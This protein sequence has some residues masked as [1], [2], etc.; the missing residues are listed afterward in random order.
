[1]YH[2]LTMPTK[3]TCPMYLDTHNTYLGMQDAYIGEN[4]CCYDRPMCVCVYYLDD[5]LNYKIVSFLLIAIIPLS[6]LL[7]FKFPINF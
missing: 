3:N 6:Y 5:V 4:A 2:S 1:M 7:I